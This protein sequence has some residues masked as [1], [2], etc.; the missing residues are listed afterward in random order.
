M[1]EL[2]LYYLH[3][4]KTAGTS[5]ISFLDN[6][7]DPSEICPAQLL[8]DLFDLPRSGLS[9]YKFFRGH[10]WHG[11]NTYLN[12]DLAYITMLRDPVQRTVSWYS[13][14]CREPHAYRHDRAVNENWSLLD[15][16]TDEATNWDLVNAQTLFLAVDLDYDKLA[17]DPVGYGQAVVRD[18]AARKSDRELLELAKTRLEQCVFVGLAERMRES[19]QLLC[20]KLGFYPRIEE[21]KLNVSGNRPPAD[22][23]SGETLAAINRITELDRELYDWAAPIF[24]ARFNDM[25]DSLLMSRWAIEPRNAPAAWKAP[26]ATA[27]RGRLAMTIVQAP[28]IAEPGSVFEA[29]VAVANQSHYRMASHPPYPLN[30]SY[31]W[32]DAATGET[33]VF[34][35]ERTALAGKCSMRANASTTWFAS[36]VRTMQA[37]TCCALRWCKKAS[38]GSTASR[39]ASGPTIPSKSHEV[40]RSVAP[41]R[42][43]RRW[44]SV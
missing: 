22:A 27:D 39:P 8:P 31:H 24:Q 20:H 37:S 44:L 35:G 7:F 29:N 16:V 6:Q 21:R 2:P 10:L 12:K 25:I 13:H 4:P 9:R 23:L 32:L 5:L 19:L 34:D 11:L 14:V 40:P 41:P 26:L 15:F 43:P 42:R 36:K 18:Y 28:R 17:K 38:H 30:L 1:T 33:V 3:I